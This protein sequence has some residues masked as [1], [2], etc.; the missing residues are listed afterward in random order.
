MGEV[1]SISSRPTAGRTVAGIR[2]SSDSR[3]TSPLPQP[4][5]GQ[6]NPR[7][8]PLT[9]DLELC[10]P[11]GSRQD[12]TPPVNM[13]SSAHPIGKALP[14]RLTKTR[15][16]V[17]TGWQDGSRGARPDTGRLRE[18]GAGGSGVGP[19]A[20]GAAAGS[21]VKGK[22]RATGTEAAEEGQVLSVD[23]KVENDGHEKVQQAEKEHSLADALQ[24]PPQQSAHPAGSLRPAQW[25]RASSCRPEQ[26]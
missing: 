17:W 7:N 22:D 11:H 23:V 20:V 6:A 3:D 14:W 15:R 21:W 13:V 19:G 24:R 16:R 2:L 10:H 4:G 26:G 8:S 5:G 18:P 1:N 12:S 25:A 9:T